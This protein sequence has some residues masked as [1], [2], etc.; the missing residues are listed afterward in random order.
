MKNSHLIVL[1]DKGAGK[2]SIIQSLN[3]NYIRASNKFIEVD[4]MGSQSAGLD[5]Q[6]LYIKDLSD[7]D[8]LNSIVTSDE[9]LPHLN[10][11]D[12]SNAEKAD[13]L[14]IVL[15]PEDLQNTCALIVLDFD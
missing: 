9:N 12:L 1:G 6:F 3:K 7:K 13:L 2:R 8:A 10:I 11:W 5:F 14:R 4:K 15:K